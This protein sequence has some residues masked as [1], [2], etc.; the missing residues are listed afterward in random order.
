MSICTV[1]DGLFDELYVQEIGA[2]VMDI[3]VAPNNIAGRQTFPYGLTG[4]HR[5]FGTTLFRRESINT[6]TKLEP[7]A[8]LFFPIL[9]QIE[10]V[11][12]TP[13]Y[14]REISLNVQCY[15]QDG[16]EHTDS[17]DPNDLTILQFTTANWKSSYGGQFELCTPHEVHEYVP[18]R[19]VILP[20]NV[21]HRGLGPTEP[22]QIRTSIVY[23][24]RPL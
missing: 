23:R 11:I 9:E 7:K 14:C 5:L 2:K 21:P 16:T 15:G 13:L 3:P 24:V 22:N 4:N 20:S 18:G 12:E 6:I 8:Q 1:I 19:I 17:Q 10:R